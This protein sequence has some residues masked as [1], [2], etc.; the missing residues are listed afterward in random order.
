LLRVFCVDEAAVPL[1]EFAGFMVEIVILGG[2]GID[3]FLRAVRVKKAR[4]TFYLKGKHF[5]G[6]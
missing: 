2:M 3:V 1:C 6:I 4:N 5:G